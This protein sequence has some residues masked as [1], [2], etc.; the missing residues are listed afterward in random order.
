MKYIITF[1]GGKDSLATII[2]AKNN[3]PDFDVV[4]CD[5]GWESEKTYLHIKEVEQWIGK[6][7][8]VLKSKKFEDLIDLFIKKKRAASTKAR[9]CTEEMKSKPMIDYVLSLNDDVTVLQ[10][11]RNEE[12]QSRKNLKMNDEY[13]KFYFEPY[14][15]TKA[16]PNKP[17]KPKFHTYNKKYVC[18]YLDLYSVDVLRP[19]IKWSAN[20]VFDFIFSANIKANPLYYEG[21]GRVGCFPCI[22]CTKSE[23]RLIYENYRERIDEIR[24]FELKLGRTF[25]PPNYIPSRFCTH[26]SVSKKGKVVMCP[27]IDDVIKYVLDDPNQIRIFK[28]VE[29]GCIS[30]YN[31]CEN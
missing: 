5:T 23:I 17:S 28:K 9:F 13:F 14:G 26:K 2:W 19:I 8:I 4:F 22:M 18:A 10:G 1:S 20:D 3:L 27:S 25:F 16:K 21:F 31:I 11:V 12:S 24:A 7:F 6:E 29:K 15:F 30:V